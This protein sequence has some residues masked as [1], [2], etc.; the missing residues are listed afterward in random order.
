MGFPGDS[1]ADLHRDMRAF[2]EGDLRTDSCGGWESDFPAD[3]YRDSD[4][5]LRRD[6]QRGLQGDLRGD[7]DRELRVTGQLL[8][9]RFVCRRDPS[10]ASGRHSVSSAASAQSAV[11]LPG[12]GCSW[13]FNSSLRFGVSFGGR[14]R[15]SGT[16]IGKDDT[17]PAALPSDTVAADKQP[18]VFRLTA[19]FS[20]L[21][22]SL[23][24]A[25][26]GLSQ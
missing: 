19:G 22:F 14:G 17:F 1:A 11:V 12:L 10:S 18:P 20:G 26:D 3:A 9:S 4:A 15:A 8:A 23:S 25:L 7:F 6:L 2:S 24:R 5:D 21:K 16:G 13:R